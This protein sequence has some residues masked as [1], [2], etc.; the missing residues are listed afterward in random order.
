MFKQVFKKLDKEISGEI[1]LNFVSE[2]CRYHRIQASP[3]I[4]AAVN[5]SVEALKGFGLDA[6]VHS[7]PADGKTLS[8]TSLH[9]KEWGCN[10]AELRLITPKEEAKILARYSEAEISVIQRSFPTGGPV[11]AEVVILEK[12]EDEADYKR[13]DVEGKIVLTSGNVSRVHELAVEKHGAIGIICDGM[14]VRPPTL[15][16]GDLDDAL[17]YTSFWWSGGEKP[18][19]GF[20]L[21][22]RQGRWLRGLIKRQEKAKD[23]V[24]LWANVDA[25]LYEG[26][27]ENAV[28]TIP[29]ETDEEVVVIAHICHPKPSANDNASGC[30]AAMEAA[31]ALQRLISEGV[32]PRP[33]RTIRFTLVPEMAGTYNYLAANEASIPRM[34]AAIN[35]DMVGESHELCK[36]IFTVLRTPESLPSYVNALVEAILDEVKKEITAFGGGPKL[37]LFRST[38]NPYSGGS[39][40]YI[41][42]DPTVGVPCPMLNQ[43]PDKFYHTSADSVDKVDPAMLRRAAM[44]TA[45]YAYSIACAGAEEAV[46]MAGEVAARERLH[47]LEYVHGVAD[48]ALDPGSEVEDPGRHMAEAL[49]RLRRVLP[50]RLGRGAEAIRSVSRLAGGDPGF[51]A[52]AARLVADLE[53]LVKAELRQA[54]A[55]IV[56]YAS[57]RGLAPLPRIRKP[58]ARKLDKQAAGM[59]PRRVYR[60][61][62]SSRSWVKKLS[63]E[64]QEGLRRLGLEHP[65]GRS[66]GSVAL[67]WTDG[68]R[69]LAE[70]SELVDLER[71]S[72]DLEYLVGY[73]GYLELMGLVEFV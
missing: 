5:Y 50:Y 43:W 48:G 37:P 47:L 13:V 58:R 3:G 60:G 18:A 69:S 55:L 15:L 24:R 9:F 62:I 63:A 21:S 28:A 39:D 16:E 14:F 32:L 45:T 67:F 52:R 8:W 11:E 42:A 19:F 31:R 35:L 57:A 38:V 72:T 41:Y 70:V 68:V 73:Y 27:I 25:S 65:A 6:E 40:H 56:D 22:P 59:V 61:P 64:D 33:R 44:L 34:V 53:R 36:S 26:A 49:A 29:G 12:G 46:W 1:A 71:G 4:R 10:E 17:K 2:I 20:V 30:G 7:Y 23:P 66:V 54:E 51:E